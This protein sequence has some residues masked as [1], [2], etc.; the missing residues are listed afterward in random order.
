MGET[1]CY[2]LADGQQ[3]GGAFTLVDEQASRGMSVPLHRHDDDVESF[4]V[5]E[6]E[7]TL[8]VGDGPGVRAGAGPVR[9]RARRY[10]STA[11]QS[12]RRRRATF[13]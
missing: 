2:F 8:F 10:G 6:G 3:T 9:A 13:S 7:V 5:L 11:S 1:S 4:Y 12:N